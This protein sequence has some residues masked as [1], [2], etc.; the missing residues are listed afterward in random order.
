MSLAY[1]HTFVSFIVH[2]TLTRY[3][4]RDAVSAGTRGYAV[5]SKIQKTIDPLVT[6]VN[7][8]KMSVF[9]N[10]VGVWSLDVK[11]K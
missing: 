5:Y 2:C 1:F 3:S 11:W 6:T 7:P 8:C 9:T 4:L 10:Q